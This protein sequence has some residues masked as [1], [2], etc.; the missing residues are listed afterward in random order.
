M[1]EGAIFCCLVRYQEIIPLG[2]KLDE[3]VGSISARAPDPLLM[4]GLQTAE[5]PETKCAV[6]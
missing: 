3:T 4:E 1:C 6:I 2:K 5:T